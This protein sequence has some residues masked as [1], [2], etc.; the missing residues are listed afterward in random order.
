M[1]ALEYAFNERSKTALCVLLQSLLVASLTHGG[2]GWCLLAL[3]PVIQELAVMLRKNT[4]GFPSQN[5]APYV[6]PV[7]V[8]KRAKDNPTEHSSC[9]SNLPIR[10][11]TF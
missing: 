6:P 8:N 1:H 5:I 3:I 10:G 9:Q 4:T 11:S 7:F 2:F